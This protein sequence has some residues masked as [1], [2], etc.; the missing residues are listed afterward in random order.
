MFGIFI[1]TGNQT[2][3][4]FCSFFTWTCSNGFGRKYYRIYKSKEFVLNG[5]IKDIYSETSILNI[6]K[7][8]AAKAGITKRVYTHLIRHCTFTHMVEN[9]T[10]INLIQRIAG[11]SNVKTTMIYC[12]LSDNLI[13]KIKSPIENIVI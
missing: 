13:S 8:L 7:A 3:Q 4:A 5:Q 1:K 11:H 9:G 6:V 10:D 12:H 2:I